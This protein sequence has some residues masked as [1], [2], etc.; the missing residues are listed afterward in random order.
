MVQLL[1]VEDENGRREGLRDFLDWTSMGIEVAG[2]ACNGMDGVK[3]A[4]AVRPQIIITDIRMPI[5]DGLEMSR[6]IRAFLP[7]ARIIILSGYDD[8]EYA[9]QTFDFNAFA[10]ILKPVQKKELEQ[11]LMS[12]LEKLEEEKRRRKAKLSLESQWMDY[13]HAKRHSL[14][15]DFLNYKTEYRFIHACPPLEN[16]KAS[17]E[18]AVAILSV[19]ETPFKSMHENGLYDKFMQEVLSLTAQ[20]HEG[21]GIAVSLG[22]FPKKRD[23]HG[24]LVWHSVLKPACFKS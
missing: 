16:L 22:E 18:K 4:E 10:Y 3:M 23:M 24:C 12:A 2:C 17:G 6:K 15:V 7:D 13:I 5:M 9:K 8:F 19:S 11:V 20:L 14:L 21:K 1:I